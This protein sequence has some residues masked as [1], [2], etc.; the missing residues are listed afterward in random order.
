[1]RSGTEGGDNLEA[2]VPIDVH[3]AD[4]L[5]DLGNMNAPAN[6]IRAYRSDLTAFA[7]HVDGDLGL[8]SK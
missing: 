8:V 1:M 3:I 6:T 7:E 5:T 4:F 2:V